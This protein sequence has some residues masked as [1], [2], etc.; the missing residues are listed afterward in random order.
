MQ[1]IKFIDA[2]KLYLIKTDYRFKNLSLNV[3]RSILFNRKIEATKINKI[4]I[5]RTGSLGDNIC[6]LPAINTIRQNF[7]TQTIDIL[8]HP[9][10]AKLVSIPNILDNSTVN[11][12]INYSGLK[13]IELIRLLRKSRYDL[14]I[15]L[16]QVHEGFVAQLRNMLF[17]CMLGAK[18]GFGWQVNATQLFSHLQ[19]EY[20]RFTNVRDSFIETLRNQGIP[21]DRIEFPL[22]INRSDEITVEKLLREKN[23]A[24][25][26]KNIAIVAG[27]KRA[28][29]RWHID[30]FKQIIVFLTNHGYNCLL[31]G[32]KEDKPITDQLA[33]MNGV[34]DF[35][36]V[37]TPMQSAYLLQNCILTVSND[38]G[39]MHL[40]Y[41]VG[42][43]VIALFSS[44]DYP[45]LWYPP[46]NLGKVFRNY[47][48]SCKACFSETCGNNLCMKAITT[49]E[50]ITAIKEQLNIA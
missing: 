17:A 49:E 43:Y 19:D 2:L 41:S 28:Q 44:R 23:C 3:C 39:P 40:S 25:K 32:G 5:F 1:K 50:V 47:S 11:N 6:S 13:L 22:A 8:Y 42:T 48:I 12:F 46:K 33:T 31:V 27:A 37:L 38:T 36:G 9:G 16:P 24:P 10:N 18:Y 29:N 20:H 4:L 26:Q 35:T 21:I 14:F 34:V 7:P 30:N 15:E 45:N